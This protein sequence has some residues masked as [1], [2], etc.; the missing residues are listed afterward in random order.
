LAADFGSIGCKQRV[1]V[2]FSLLHGDN[3][4]RSHQP[5]CGKARIPGRI[6]P[7]LRDGSQYIPPGRLYLH[8][9]R[10]LEVRIEESRGRHPRTSR[11]L[12]PRHKVAGSIFLRFDRWPKPFPN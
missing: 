11:D 5:T 2:V 12:C 7:V 9:C 8:R 3:L 4:G 1:E 10:K 6:G